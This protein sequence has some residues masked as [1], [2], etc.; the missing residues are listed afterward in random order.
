MSKKKKGSI[1]C[2]FWIAL[3]LL[4]IVI[5]MFNQ[6]SIARVVRSTGICKYIPKLPFCTEKDN[7]AEAVHYTEEPA[8]VPDAKPEK[9][10]AVENVIVEVDNQ[11]APEVEKPVE[12]STEKPVESNNEPE[13][14]KKKMRKSNLYYVRFNNDDTI[15]LEKIQRP[16][17]YIDAPLTETLHALLSP[18][19]TNEIDNGLMSA[20]PQGTELRSSPTIKNGIV[21]LN[22]NTEF[23]STKMGRESSIFMLRQIIYTCTEFP[24]VD[25]VQFLINGKMQNYLSSDGIAID[26]P[27]GRNDL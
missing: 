21:Y 20:I 2:L 5:F 27:L 3:I 18:L 24:T 16:V 12:E 25:K 9:P 1:G 17:Y 11:P 14:V 15:Q 19:G 6:K 26:K 7:T 8:P 22:F 13:I 23:T 10:S 4:V